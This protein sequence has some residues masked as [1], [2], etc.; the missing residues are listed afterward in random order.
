MNEGG[1][2]KM[3]LEDIRDGEFAEGFS[4]TESEQ[5]ALTCVQNKN[6]ALDSGTHDP[7]KS[8]KRLPYN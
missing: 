5:V 8:D 3:G 4:C 7:A 1:K 2:L 6:Y